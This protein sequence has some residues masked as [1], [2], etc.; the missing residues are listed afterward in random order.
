MSLTKSALRQDSDALH[1]G[2]SPV[3]I[4]DDARIWERTLRAAMEALQTKTDNLQWEINRLDAENRR[5]RSEHPDVSQC[6]DLE[7]KLE[8]AKSD[9]TASAERAQT[10]E[11]QLRELRQTVDERSMDAERDTERYEE[12]CGELERTREEF[13]TIRD[14]AANAREA[15]AEAEDAVTSLQAQLTTVC[16]ELERE[17]RNLRDEMR[18][19]R[20]AIEK[21]GELERY[22]ALETERAKWEARE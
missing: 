5:L 11:E 22:C 21:D 17:L 4:A 18:W 6:V 15:T 12:V 19:E 10:Y 2:A 13:Q 1:L 16:E 20:E 8:Q 3:T 7:I 9:A 14:S